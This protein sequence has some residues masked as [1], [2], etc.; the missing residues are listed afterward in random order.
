M[1][2]KKTFPPDTRLTEIIMYNKQTQHLHRLVVLLFDGQDDDDRQVSEP[3]H[4][5]PIKTTMWFSSCGCTGDKHRCRQSA[6]DRY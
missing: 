1:K 6:K 5:V 4:R 3:H 2:K